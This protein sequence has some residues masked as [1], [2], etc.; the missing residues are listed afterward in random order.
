MADRFFVALEER[1]IFEISG[2]DRREFLQG[3]IT[4]DVSKVAPG[5]ALYSAFLTAQGRYLHDFFMTEIDD[6]LF[7]DVEL[8]RQADLMRRLGIFKLRAKVGLV[9]ANDRLG[10]AAA[11][12]N[13]ALA[14]LGLSDA[15]G[16][17]KAF[18]GGIAY[19][20]PR[21]PALGA[22]FLLPRQSGTTS[23]KN[24]GFAPGSFRRL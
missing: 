14:A 23:L 17:A 6:F 24:A 8:S 2:P 9:P 11:F 10:A 5:H 18:D 1:G 15:P 3:L 22:R 12:G 7:V 13:D 19:V 16:A 4:N 20:D 21:L